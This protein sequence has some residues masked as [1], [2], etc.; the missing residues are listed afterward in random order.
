MARTQRLLVFLLAALAVALSAAGP[1]AAAE[2][3]APPA[4][5]ESAPEAMT[6]EFPRAHAGLVGPRAL[7]PVKCSGAVAAMCEGTLVLTGAGGAH[8]VPYAIAQG[9]QQTLVVPIGEKVTAHGYKARV[10]A[11]TLQ[12]TGGLVRTSRI[13]RVG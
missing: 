3:E 2:P 10:V 8:K 11:R 5:E 9:E 6:V 12:M 4:G 13:L 1:V 7:V